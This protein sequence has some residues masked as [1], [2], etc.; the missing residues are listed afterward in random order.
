MD[1]IKE[2]AFRLL[3]KCEIVTIATV[4]DGGF[5]YPVPV[6]KIAAERPFTVWIATGSGSEKVRHIRR[7][8]RC[9]LSF[10]DRDDSVSLTGEAEVVSEPSV[11]RAMWQDW[12]AG[13][14]PGGPDDPAYCLVRFHAREGTFYIGGEFVRLPAE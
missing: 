5:P 13:H 6:A 9:G 8:A 11:R 4:G 2:R 14:F 7:D 12:F 1:T 3:D 10:F